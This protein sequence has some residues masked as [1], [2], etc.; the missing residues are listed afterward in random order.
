MSKLGVLD[1]VQIVFIILKILKLVDWSWWA[2][3]TPIWIAIAF[4]VVVGVCKGL[5]GKF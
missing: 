3:L 5:G 1:V 2:V 4:G